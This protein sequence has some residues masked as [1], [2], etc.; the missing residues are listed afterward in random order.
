M[1]QRQRPTN[2]HRQLLGNRQPQP[3]AAGAAVARI[4]HAVERLHDLLQFFFGNPRAAVHDG[5]QQAAVGSGFHVQLSGASVLQCV[6]RQVDQYPAQGVGADGDSHGQPGAGDVLLANTSSEGIG[7]VKNGVLETV[8]KVVNY[9]VSKVKADSAGDNARGAM[10][11]LAGAVQWLNSPALSNESLKG[12]VA[13]VDFWTFD[14]INCH[15]GEGRYD[16]QE[17]MIQQLLEEARQGATAP[18][19]A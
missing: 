2:R 14:C 16:E 11:S 10:P 17:K 18:D 9:I 3:C 15:F 19:A 4:F 13:L 1:A 8:P 7:R 5:D 12:K 6:V